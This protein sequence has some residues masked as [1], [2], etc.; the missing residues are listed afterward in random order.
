MKRQYIILCNSFYSHVI[1]LGTKIDW[2][3]S[4]MDYRFYSHV[5]CLGTKMGASTS[6]LIVQFYSHVIC[7]GTKMQAGQGNQQVGF[8]VT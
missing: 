1:C 3:I 6:F 4:V 5:I 8:T 7:L 2:G